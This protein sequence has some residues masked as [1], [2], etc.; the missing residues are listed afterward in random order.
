MVLGKHEIEKQLHDEHKAI[1]EGE[2]KEDNPLD[3][4][5]G[6]RELCEACRK[7]DLKA[8]QEKLQEGV[9]VNARDR[10][11]YTPLILVWRCDPVTTSVITD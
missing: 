6:F 9:N 10:F 4:S 3:S 8:C 7:G 1:S 2:L 11:D 5:E